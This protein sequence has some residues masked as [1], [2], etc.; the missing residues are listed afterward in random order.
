MNATKIK[1]GAKEAAGRVEGAA[2][3][4]GGDPDLELKGRVDE[5]AGSAQK[6]FGE[7]VEMGEEAVARMRDFVEEEPWKAVAIAGAVGLLIGLAVRR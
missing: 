3:I 7:A 6:A 4:L 1:G 5:L 2:G